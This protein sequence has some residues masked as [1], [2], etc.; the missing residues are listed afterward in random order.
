MTWVEM[1]MENSLHLV[2]HNRLELVFIAP[3][4][5]VRLCDC[6]KKLKLIRFFNA[7]AARGLLRVAVKHSARLKNT[8]QN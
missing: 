7:V 2:A 6:F 8:L 1:P 4:K 5:P 3:L